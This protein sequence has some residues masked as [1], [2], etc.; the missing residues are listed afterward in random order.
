MGGGQARAPRDARLAGRAAR[1][2]LED[3]GVRP[4]RLVG[5]E[6]G[7]EPGLPGGLDDQGPR[8]EPRRRGGAPH[9]LRHHPGALQG[10]L[11]GAV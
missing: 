11:L 10:E 6:G 8:R 7:L 3:R 5:P 2:G 4:A 9:R 1:R